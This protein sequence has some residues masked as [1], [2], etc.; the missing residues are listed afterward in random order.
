MLPVEIDDPADPRLTDYVGLTD[1]VRRLK[2]EPVSGFFLAEGQLVMR[3]AAQSGCPPRSLLLAPNRVADL[4][5]E[6]RSLD[7]PVYVASAEV[8]HA[9][10]GFHVHRGALGSFGRLP[11]AAA[12]DVLAASRRVLVLEEVNSPTNLGAIFRS[13]AGLGMDA[14]LLSPTCCDPL[15]RRA[16][17]VS[18]GEVLS[19]PYAY[20][21]HWPAGLA[22][23][24]DA[25]FRVLALTPSAT[26]VALDDVVIAADDRVA[27]LLGAEGPGLSAD[28]LAASD[29]QVRIPMSA[30]VDSLNVAAATAIA[31]WAI[32]RRP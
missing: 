7:C 26:A 20:L 18:M 3:R 24:R 6:L 13:A 10:T 8:L 21:E 2:H 11:V 23:V 9:V 14:V 12:T 31:C 15:Y 5:P 27:V 1:V 30:G 16:V 4:L 25:G 17:R 28:A 22:A 32:G 19:V 29:A